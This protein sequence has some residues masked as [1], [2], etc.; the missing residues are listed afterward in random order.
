MRFVHNGGAFDDLPIR[1]Q[2]VMLNLC[3]HQGISSYSMLLFVALL[4]E[5]EILIDVVMA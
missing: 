4:I 1:V 2:V 5:Y 3:K